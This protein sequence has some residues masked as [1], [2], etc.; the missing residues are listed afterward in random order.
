[1]VN[2]KEITDKFSL[3]IEKILHST[4]SKIIYYL[5]DKNGKRFVLKFNKH[6]KTKLRTEQKFLTRIKNLPF[7]YVRFPQLIEYGTN[8][9]L[10]DYIEREHWTRETILEKKWSYNEIQLWVSG[11]REFQNV[12]MPRNHFSLKQRLM[13]FIY[14]VFRVF[15]LL[16]KC[17]KLISFRALGVILKLTLSYS[18]S[19]FFFKNTL[20]H[21]DLQMYNYTFMN[22]EKKMSMID[23]EM[24]YYG[25]D[26]LFDV[27]YYISI[28]IR[29][30]E[31]WT[32]QIDLLK[33][34][35]KQEY[36]GAWHSKSL[37][38]RMRLIL[39]VSNL[40]RYLGFIN[41]GDKKKI[42]S[43]NIRILL[44]S[45]SFSRWVASFSG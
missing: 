12:D 31:D 28:P 44:D 27:L 2:V 19:R 42:Y 14:P 25:G 24:P 35:I 11:L 34:Y 45:K 17:R 9:I 7:R 3:R 23:F 39:L 33:E 36:E 4:G 5:V 20:T 37:L 21:Y 26:P 13:G 41:D 16:P 10:I 30:F 43:E 15:I 40:S 29:K 18:L 38:C 6:N 1:M 8:H 32:F 22:N